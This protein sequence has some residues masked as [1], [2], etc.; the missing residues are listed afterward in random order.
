VAQD[1]AEMMFKQIMKEQ[2]RC[3]QK[4]ETSMVFAILDGRLG[5][6]NTA[7]KGKTQQ[8]QVMTSKCFRSDQAPI[9]TISQD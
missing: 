8:C 2:E 3:E 6:A 4:S 5:K 7:D 1:L 9:A